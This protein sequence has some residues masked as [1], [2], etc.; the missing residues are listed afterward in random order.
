[1]IYLYILTRNYIESTIGYHAENKPYFNVSKTNYMIITNEIPY[2]VFN[3]ENWKL[4][5]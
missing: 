3:F 5:Y 4:C 2:I 1:M